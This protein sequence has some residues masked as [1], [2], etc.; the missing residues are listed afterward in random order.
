MQEFPAHSQM[1]V[2]PPEEAELVVWEQEVG[3]DEGA[4]MSLISSSI[5]RLKAS[6]SLVAG[7]NDELG[8]VAR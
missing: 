8:F 5:L 6:D 3:R 1:D 4:M 2:Q 7:E